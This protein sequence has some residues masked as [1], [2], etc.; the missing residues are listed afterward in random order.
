[1]YIK[2]LLR[3][4]IST[5]FL[6]A[7]LVFIVQ[8]TYSQVLLEN[9]DLIDFFAE[10]VKVAPKD[11]Y[12][13]FY[14][15]RNSDK[16]EI[17]KSEIS[18]SKGEVDS[19]LVFI[20]IELYPQI[21][22][23]IDRYISDIQEVYGY[24]I[25]LF[26][27]TTSISPEEI[28]QQIIDKNMINPVIGAV[29]IGD[30][31]VAFY[32]I[33]NDF[34]SYGYAQWPCDLY[35][36]DLDGEWLDTDNNSVYDTHTGD[37]NPE[38]FIGR[39]FPTMGTLIPDMIQAYI[40]YFD[41]NHRF[42][43][44]ETVLNHQKGLSY[45]DH[46][47]ASYSDLNHDI[48]YLYGS[49][50]YENINQIDHPFFNSV[51]YSDRL[52]NDDYEFVQLNCHS[53]DTYHA[54]S[55]GGN[56]ASNSIIDRS[57]DAVGYNLFCCS[58]LRWTAVAQHPSYGFLGGAYIY[59]NGS[60]SLNVVG[61]TKTGSMLGFSYFYNPLGEGKSVGIAMKEWWT[62]FCGPTHTDSELSW[63][64]GMSIL[65]DPLVNMLYDVEVDID[66]NYE[67]QITNYELKQNYPNPFNPVTRI[68]FQ[69]AVSSEQLAEIVVYNSAGQQ[70]WFSQLT[71]HSSQL[72]GSILFDGSKFNSGIYYYSLVIDG[73][74]MDTKSMVLIK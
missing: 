69:L 41:K 9:Q 72:T 74:K 60:K 62:N 24:D 31:S 70:V 38:I 56:L 40:D 63:H 34:G 46:D 6:I 67:L 48:E 17:K 10:D 18:S 13:D 61:S 4:I 25:V 54:F 45:V 23:S 68:R 59:N 49:E 42:W 33:E 44:G 47:W 73:K 43:S 11:T 7:I 37:V 14:R 36:M 66:D 52:E 30:L 35:M 51:D 1:M 28:K 27:V 2:W 71:A 57:L 26:E 53:S 3:K 65:G 50:N 58:S 22:F 12:E 8:P 20:D 16:V 64:Y 39:I 15:M 21:S 29:L 5:G 19:Y 55:A 32:E